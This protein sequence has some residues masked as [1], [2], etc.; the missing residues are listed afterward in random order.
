MVEPQT[1]TPNANNQTPNPNHHV[2]V[3][4]RVALY[5]RV[6]CCRR[7]YMPV[8]SAAAAA[9][10]TTTAAA[11]LVILDRHRHHRCTFV[12][13]WCPAFRSVF[14]RMR[15]WQVCQHVLAKCHFLPFVWPFRS[16]S[17]NEGVVLCLILTLCPCE[18]LW[19]VCFD[20]EFCRCLMMRCVLGSGCCVYNDGRSACPFAHIYSCLIHA[21]THI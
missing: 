14:A 12:F 7:L 17:G 10:G 15:A 13:V 4:A 8:P 21:H 3:R 20:S 1:E 5:S 16:L 18:L 19:W 2:Q 9:A 6:R 11:A